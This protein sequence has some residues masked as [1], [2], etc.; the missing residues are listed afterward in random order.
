VIVDSD[1]QGF[2]AG[3]LAE[4]AQASIAAQRDLR[5]AGHALDIEVEK[6]AG[7]GMFVALDWGSRVQI[8]PAAKTNAAQDAA[9]GGRTNG[10]AAGDLIGWSV[11]AAQLNHAF[12]EVQR[13]AT[14]TAER[15]GTEI[16]QARS[17]VIAVSAYP[18]AGSLDSD[19]K[20]GC[21]RLP[22]TS[23]IQHQLD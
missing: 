4:A 6:V 5:K 13:K 21:S 12:D 22:G 7:V 11:L 19:P 15:A 10:S 18:L 17:A 16:A 9:D 23:L 20:G 1:V 8:A 14:R 3:V 2:K